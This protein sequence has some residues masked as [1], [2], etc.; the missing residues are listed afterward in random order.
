MKKN[1]LLFLLLFSSFVWSQENEV[2]KIFSHPTFAFTL[3]SNNYFG[4]NYLSKGHENSIGIQFKHEF[5]HF[6]KINLGFGFEK[7]TQKVTDTSI[8]GNSNKTNTNSIFGFISYN[9]PINN[10]FEI[11]P[12][13][14]YGGIELKQKNGNKLYGI[15]QG[16]RFGLALSLDYKIK[17]HL[18]IYS[19][20]GY[21]KYNL[22]TKTTSEFVNYFNS[23]NAI[24]YSLGLK[25]NI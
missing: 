10:S 16:Y 23:A 5:V 20:I 25:F 24:S 17:K 12:E 4:D 7:S 8:G 19:T 2:A 21:N 15:Q 14:N 11:S 22:N 1:I 18:S 6:K 9:I 13:I 3:I